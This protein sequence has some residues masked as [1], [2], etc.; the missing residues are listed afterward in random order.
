MLNPGRK[1]GLILIKGQLVKTRDFSS[2]GEWRYNS[3][4]S[5][6]TATKSH[7]FIL[8]VKCIYNYFHKIVYPLQISLW[9]E[10]DMNVSLSG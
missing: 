6:R 4:G 2:E 3:F 9:V 5:L 1:Y 10:M 8:F 7:K